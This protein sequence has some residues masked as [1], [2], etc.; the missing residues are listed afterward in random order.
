MRKVEP[1]DKRL[2]ERAKQEPFPQNNGGFQEQYCREGD[3]CPCGIVLRIKD[4]VQKRVGQ[5]VTEEQRML[6][7]FF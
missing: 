6:F 1:F 4:Q 2:K 7:L 3:A 5:K